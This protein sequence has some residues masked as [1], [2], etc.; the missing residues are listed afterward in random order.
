MSNARPPSRMDPSKLARPLSRADLAKSTRTG[1]ATTTKAADKPK[2]AEP[3]LALSKEV[4]AAVS[5]PLPPS[6]TLPLASAADSLPPLKLETEVE[7]VPPVTMSPRKA[8]AETKAVHALKMG[9]PLL[10]TPPGTPSPATKVEDVP[11]RVATPEAVGEL[12][13]PAIE[14]VQELTQIQEPVVQVVEQHDPVPNPVPVAKQP[15]EPSSVFVPPVEPSVP[16]RVKGKEVAKKVG[17]LVAHFEDPNRHKPVRP[18]RMVEQ[19]PISALVSTIRKGFEDMK[20][21]PALGIIEEGDSVDMTPPP[22][23]VGGLRVGG[24]VGLNIRSKSGLGER[25][26]LTTMRLNS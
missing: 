3:L 8:T 17:D 10:D 24:V 11:S 16:L 18:P 2:L 12:E 13:A 25:T 9:L 19:T 1:V 14:P 5:V 15:T 20:P 7:F 4:E 6:P 21:L 23:P 26:A 22:R